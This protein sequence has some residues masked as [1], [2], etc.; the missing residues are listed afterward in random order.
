MPPYYYTTEEQGDTTILT[1]NISN[2]DPLVV[3]RP[4]RVGSVIDVVRDFAWTVSPK[5]NEEYAQVLYL[6]FR[7]AD[8]KGLSRVFV[9]PPTGDGIAVAVNDRLSK[10]ASEK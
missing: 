3:L 2:T 9:I 8:T 6:A 10:S 5:T 7:L 1:V 4:T